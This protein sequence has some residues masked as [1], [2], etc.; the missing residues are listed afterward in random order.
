MSV[1]M[2]YMWMT[3]CIHVICMAYRCSYMYMQCKVREV[4]TCYFC[5]GEGC[6]RVLA[7]FLFFGGFPKTVAVGL[8]RKVG[9]K[10]NAEIVGICCIWNNV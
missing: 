8:G 10:R 1:H 7:L 5:L 2:G 6:L 4:V 9:V 3:L